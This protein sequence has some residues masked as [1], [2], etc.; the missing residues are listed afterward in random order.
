MFTIISV[1]LISE[2]PEKREDGNRSVRYQ[3]IS[4]QSHVTGTPFRLHLAN[5]SLQINVSQR[6]TWTHRRPPRLS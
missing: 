4:L 5:L 6:L 3:S 2:R 1:E